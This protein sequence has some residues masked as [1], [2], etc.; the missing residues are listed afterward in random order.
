LPGD[1]HG[2]LFFLEFY[3]GDVYRL[4]RGGSGW[5]LVPGRGRSDSLW[6]SGFAIASDFQEGP[7]GA[8]WLLGMGFGQGLAAGVHR[9][10]S[11][12]VWS[13][14]PAPDDLRARPN[15]ARGGVAVLVPSPTPGPWTLAIRDVEGRLV[16]FLSG[17]SD[18]GGEVSWDGRS[19]NGALAA[20]G[21]YFAEW[22]A[23]PVVARGKIA[24]LR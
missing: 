18:P 24:L 1:Y 23:G 17:P 14:A 15:P 8:L 13:E 9:I 16:Q 7:D 11:T 4:R 19:A 12:R 21:V 20:A 5:S 22:R 6:A 2:D 3:R 10:F